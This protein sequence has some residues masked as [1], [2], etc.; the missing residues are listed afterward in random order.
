MKRAALLIGVLSFGFALLVPDVAG[1][2][3]PAAQ[4]KPPYSAIAAID[5]E[6]PKGMRLRRARKPAEAWNDYFVEVF[7]WP[8]DR[9]HYNRIFT[10]L[11][12]DG[13]KVQFVAD[14]L[15][16]ADGNLHLILRGEAATIRFLVPGLTLH[17]GDGKIRL[18]PRGVKF[19]SDPA[20]GAEIGI[21]SFTPP[22]NL[23]L[24]QWQ[25]AFAFYGNAGGVAQVRS[26]AEAAKHYGLLRDFAEVA[27][28]IYQQELDAKRRR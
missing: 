24:A 27:S 15:F 23:E 16:L 2:S 12:R 28:E 5:P 3:K 21:V 25:S 7:L 20:G 11:N 14:T 18:S 22:A 26:E 4:T 8:Y 1:K 6:N 17:T 10:T 19:V 9:E 13:R